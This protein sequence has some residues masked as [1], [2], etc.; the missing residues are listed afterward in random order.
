MLREWLCHGKLTHYQFG[1]RERAIHG[2]GH[3]SL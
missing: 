1:N 2:A 3:E